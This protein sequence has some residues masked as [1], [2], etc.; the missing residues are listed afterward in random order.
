MVKIS[1][2]NKEEIRKYLSNIL[3]LINIYQTDLRE[4]RP[5]LIKK[6]R[7]IKVLIQKEKWDAIDLKELNSF[8]KNE[9]KELT[10]KA[11]NEIKNEINLRKTRGMRFSGKCPTNRDLYKH[12][13]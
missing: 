10:L 5:A 2:S 11:I 7:E 8:C 3:T 6:E 9:W 4:E 13:I 1:P 12:T